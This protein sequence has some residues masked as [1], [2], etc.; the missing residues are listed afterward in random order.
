MRGTCKCKMRGRLP[1]RPRGPGRAGVRRDA[2]S[3]APGGGGR[4][5]PCPQRARRSGVCGF[6]FGLVRPRLVAAHRAWLR[7]PVLP[8]LPLGAR[9]SAVAALARSVTGRGRAIFRDRRTAVLLVHRLRCLH[10]HAS[11]MVADAVLDAARRSSIP[12]KLPAHRLLEVPK[13]DAPAVCATDEATP[14]LV[15]EIGEIRAAV[16]PRI[17]EPGADP[18]PIRRATRLQGSGTALPGI[19]TS[20]RQIPDNNLQIESPA[21]YRCTGLQDGL[22]PR[23]TRG[24][25][26]PENEPPRFR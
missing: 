22:P 18:R 17:P 13:T 4:G 6:G 20:H 11:S 1:H 3:D 9:V 10:A 16:A 5:E 26:A 14:A 8:A 19:S 15:V 24:Y 7:G 25:P 23:M 21:S 2:I 12:G